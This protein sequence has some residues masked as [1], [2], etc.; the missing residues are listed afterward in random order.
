M[1]NRLKKKLAA[2][3]LLEEQLYE[4]VVNEMSGGEIR[5]GLWAKALAMGDG[6]D[7][8]TK[9]H[10]IKYRVQ[11]LKDEANLLIELEKRQRIEQE[12]AAKAKRLERIDELSKLLLSKGYKLYSAEGGG[13]LVKEPLGGKQYL[14]SLQ[15]VEIYANSRRR[16]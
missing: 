5:S 12:E 15:D 11:S 9:S 10:Y 3:R 1:F 7:G 8:S 2:S 4:I 16:S 6:S 14:G 13:W